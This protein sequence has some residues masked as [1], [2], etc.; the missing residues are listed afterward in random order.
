MRPADEGQGRAQVAY[1]A[2]AFLKLEYF[3]G[4]IFDRSTFWN[5]TV[6]L[7]ILSNRKCHMNEFVGTEFLATKDGVSFDK[8][9]EIPHEKSKPSIGAAHRK[10]LA[11]QI[12]ENQTS[13]SREWADGGGGS[14]Y[15]Q[16]LF[17]LN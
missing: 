12:Q 3:F 7:N 8:S 15:L 16:S 13:S 5:P 4:D 2:R 6:Y 1:A 11:E 9:R 10:T 14:K 17:V